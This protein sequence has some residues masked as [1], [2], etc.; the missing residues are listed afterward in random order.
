MKEFFRRISG[1]TAH[2]VGTHWA[3][4][5]ACATV[6]ACGSTLFGYS[7]ICQPVINTGTTIV[8]FLMVFLI[9]NTEN[10]FSRI[11]NPTLDERFRGVE[12]ADISR[13]VDEM[14]D[15][16]LAHVERELEARKEEAR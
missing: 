3:F 5:M 4:L 16:D 8:T 13:R 9:K 15:G 11:P 2:I 14:S 10:R 7:D 12:G 1:A 6:V